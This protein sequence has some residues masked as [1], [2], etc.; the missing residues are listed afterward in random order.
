MVSWCFGVGLHVVSVQCGDW[1]DVF[2]D[3][4]EKLMGVGVPSPADLS[5]VEP[6]EIAEAVGGDLGRKAFARRVLRHFSAAE[7][8][9]ADVPKDQPGA[10]V[11]QSVVLDLGWWS[12]WV[13][14]CLRQK[15]P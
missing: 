4:A 13:R 6:A 7:S 11:Q 5:G 15:L 14:R 9:K 2:K 1:C 10:P 3:V 12:F 8:A